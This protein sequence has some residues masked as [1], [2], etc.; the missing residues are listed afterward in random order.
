MPTGIRNIDPDSTRAL[1]ATF[2]EIASGPDGYQTVTEDHLAAI[3]NA[4]TEDVGAD[5]AAVELEPIVA[6]ED[7]ADAAT[8]GLDDSVELDTSALIGFTRSSGDIKR[9]T[10]ARLCAKDDQTVLIIGSLQVPVEQEGKELRVGRLK[11]HASEDYERVTKQTSK[12]PIHFHYVRFA[13]SDSGDSF[14]ISMYVRSDVDAEAVKPHLK[15]GDS[16]SEILSAPGG[17]GASRLTDFLG[18]DTQFPWSG[19][20]QKLNTRESDSP[21]AVD[22]MSFS[23]TLVSGETLYLRGQAEKEAAA[24]RTKIEADLASKP[25]SWTLKVLYRAEKEGGK[26]IMPTKLVSSGRASLFQAKLAASDAAVVGELPA[27]AEKEEEPASA[28][29]AKRR[30]AF[31]KSK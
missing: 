1:L 16:L 11:A 19:A 15:A 25:G 27:A 8:D 26:V 18:A 5:A 31:A 4:V 2:D 28:A 30:N 21:Y 12:D 17:G 13:D 24:R 23:V 6:I 14:D 20:I 7:L 3:K 29:P 9:V 10:P 22:G